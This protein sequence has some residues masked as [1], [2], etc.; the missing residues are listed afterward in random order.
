MHGPLM[1]TVFPVTNTLFMPGEVLV[2]WLEHGLLLIIP[3]LLLNV[4][5]VPK[6]RFEL[7]SDC[8]TAARALGVFL[9]INR[10]EA[11]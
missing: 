3:F 8:S 11:L 10:A 5:T 7:N 1:A 4:Y 2:Y 9:G 6:F